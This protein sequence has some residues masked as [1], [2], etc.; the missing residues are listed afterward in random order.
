MLLYAIETES[1]GFERELDGSGLARLEENFL[2]SLE[3][4][5]RTVDASHRIRYVKLDYLCAFSV[6][7]IRYRYGDGYLT[8]SLYGTFVGVCVSELECG[9]A[10]SV[11]ERPLNRNVLSLVPSVTYIYASS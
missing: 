3:L 8:V 4:L 11:S 9:V 1:V 10:K 2:E 7:G 5:Y 6:A